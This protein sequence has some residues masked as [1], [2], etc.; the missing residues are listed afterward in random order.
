[1]DTLLPTEF[2]AYALAAVHTAI[3]LALLWVGAWAVFWRGTTSTLA[4]LD[5]ELQRQKY[6][7]SA[8]EAE[9]RRLGTLVRQLEERQVVE[10]RYVAP[11]PVPAPVPRPQAS[12]FEM[13]IRMAGS[14]ATE[15]ELV[16][17]C[18]MSREEASLMVRLHG[19]RA[20][21]VA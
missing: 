2:Q 17:A 15:A 19:G 3:L 12:G 21:S 20:R 11:A 7:V 10:A 4:R 1:M 18:G 9:A 16:A 8:S 6:Q 13:A 14:G 5:A